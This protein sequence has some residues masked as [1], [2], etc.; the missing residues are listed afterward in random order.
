MAETQVC[1]QCRVGAAV[2]ED[3]DVQPAQP[4][5]LDCALVLVKVGDPVLNY[6]ELAG[7]AM[8]TL[9]LASRGTTETIPFG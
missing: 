5:C 1:A 2:V 4:W 9:A 7:G 8:Y 3:L 6:R